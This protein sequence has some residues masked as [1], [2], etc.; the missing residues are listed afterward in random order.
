MSLRT[1]EVE[2]TSAGQSSR[3]GTRTLYSSKLVKVCR[4]YFRSDIKKG[5]LVMECPEIRSLKGA[6]VRCV[7]SWGGI[8]T[9]LRITVKY[10][11]V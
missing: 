11:I 2:M 8:L 6:V 7:M 9:S 4:S 5:L 3:Q 10:D 1:A